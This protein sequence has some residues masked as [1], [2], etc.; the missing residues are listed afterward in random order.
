MWYHIWL[1]VFYFLL[2]DGEVFGDYA[3]MNDTELECSYITA[4]PCELIILSG[5]NVRKLITAE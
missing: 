5:F 2:G 4:I 3:L 1:I